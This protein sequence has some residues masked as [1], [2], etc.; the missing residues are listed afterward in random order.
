MA[1]DIKVNF[2]S[3]DPSSIQDTRDIHWFD[4]EKAAMLKSPEKTEGI[5]QAL[6]VNYAFDL[7]KRAFSTV[8]GRIGSYTGDYLLQNRV[9]NFVALGSLGLSIATG[10]PVMI[11]NSLI[12]IGVGAADLQMGM[13]KANVE[14]SVLGNLT[15][16][17]ATNRS[18]GTGGKI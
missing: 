15:N 17:S 4:A 16:T 1:Y 3:Q 14:A 18:R 9:N 11:A 5:L 12:N 8:A 13:T 2:G 7:G 6:S 10:N